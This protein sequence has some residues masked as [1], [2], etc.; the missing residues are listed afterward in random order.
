MSGLWS[1][2][3][4]L[5]S[6]LFKESVTFETLF[7]FKT[8]STFF[9]R[10]CLLTEQQQTRNNLCLQVLLLLLCSPE[11]TVFSLGGKLGCSLVVWILDVVFITAA[12]LRNGSP[13]HTGDGLLL[14]LCLC[15]IA[16][17]SAIQEWA[18]RGGCFKPWFMVGLSLLAVG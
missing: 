10:N 9:C 16:N 4:C 15:T 3:K 18:R 7:W 12:C 1:N 13:A 14:C 6:S 2:Q 5:F 17:A 11:L 8:M